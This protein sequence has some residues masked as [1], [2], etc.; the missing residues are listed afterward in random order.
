M[1]E[2]PKP[3]PSFFFL[4][5]ETQRDFKGLD[6]IYNQCHS[7]NPDPLTTS[8]A[9]YHNHMIKSSCDRR[10]EEGSWSQGTLQEVSRNPRDKERGSWGPQDTTLPLSSAQTSQIGLGK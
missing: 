8:L 4:H 5:K 1:S 6:H 9:L 2:L 3:A 10:A 7:A